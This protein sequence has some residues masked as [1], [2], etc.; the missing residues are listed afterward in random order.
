MEHLKAVIN[1]GLY[2]FAAERRKQEGYKSRDR[3]R[4]DSKSSKERKS[5]NDKVSMSRTQLYSPTMILSSLSPLIPKDM[6]LKVENSHLTG[7][8]AAS[9]TEFR[10]SLHSFEIQTS[11]LLK[12][13]GEDVKMYYNV[14]SV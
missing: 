9:S 7:M 10:A 5:S 1:D 2:T 4:K 13:A 3:N 12:L 11:F 14:I 6:S 8:R